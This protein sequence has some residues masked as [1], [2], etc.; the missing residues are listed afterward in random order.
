MP[1]GITVTPTAI[2][3]AM[4]SSRTSSAAAAIVKAA[5]P[6][7]TTTTRPRSRGTRTP[8]AIM[9]TIVGALVVALTGTAANHIRVSRP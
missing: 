4:A 2:P 6:M 3:S 1:K 9:G 8:F 5:L 7:A